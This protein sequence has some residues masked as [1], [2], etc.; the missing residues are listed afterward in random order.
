MAKLPI[1]AYLGTTQLFKDVTRSS[2]LYNRPSDWLTLPDAPEPEG[3]K[4]L[5][6]VFDS[7]SNFVGIRCQGAYTIDWGDGSA[8]QDYA[9]NTTAY[10]N[11][12]WN[13]ISS[14]TLTSGGYRQAIITITPQAEENLT[15]ISLS[16]KHNESGLVSLYSS[17]WLD[18]NLN[19]PNLASGGQRMTIGSSVV[20]C[21]FLERV[22]IKSWGALT[23]LASAFQNC[24]LLQSLNEYEWNTANITSFS[25]TFNGCENLKS[26]DTTNWNL[27]SVDTFFQAF[28]VCTS[29]TS[30]HGIENWNVSNV[31]NFGSTFLSCN[32]LFSENRNLNLNNWNTSKV[33]TTNGM[34]RTNT[35]L[36]YIGLSS[37]DV[38]N[39]TTIEAMF[40]GTSQL[41]KV[42]LSTWNLSACTNAS[43][44][45]QNC[46]VLKEINLPNLSSVTN[47]G[48]SF[49][50]N[51]NNLSNFTFPA[52]GINASINFT[53]CC[54]DAA[55]LDYI[56]TNLSSTGSGKTINVTGNH[57]TANDDPTIATN[58]GWTVT[59]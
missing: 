35:V 23:S 3:I 29:L 25:N 43:N 13:N 8:P 6:A 11:Y 40:N 47:F 49:A 50:A 17:G 19:L 38:S 18:I 28:R 30:L 45:F 22:Y 41:K 5:H 56:Y 34:F 20:R 32:V 1:R 59:G 24:K 54:F 4:A 39:V 46:Q 16:E 37:W 36:E 57:G 9:S 21:G 42:D 15:L 58:K 33:T 51:A 26:L 12:D 10:Y 52:S 27:S 14:S 53:N 31:T 48:A 7:P 55:T 44:L 2:D